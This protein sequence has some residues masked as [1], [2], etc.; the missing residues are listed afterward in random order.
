MTVF[1]LG[2]GLR[3]E[4]SSAS[5]VGPVRAVNEDSM[6]VGPPVFAVADGMGGHA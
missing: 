5:E 2:E 6:L 1:Q 3:V 4:V